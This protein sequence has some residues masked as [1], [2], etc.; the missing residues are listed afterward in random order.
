MKILFFNTSLKDRLP[1]GEVV[2]LGYNCINVGEFLWE[3]TK[4]SKDRVCGKFF[5]RGSEVDNEW[6]AEGEYL[7]KCVKTNLLC[8][9]SGAE[10]LWILKDYENPKDIRYHE[11]YE[12]Y[13]LWRKKEDK[14]MKE[15]L[16]V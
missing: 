4:F 10:P 7:Y 1:I 9:G 12:W 14:K 8:R 13:T 2:R 11:G 6:S 3:T 16:S 5:Y 15:R